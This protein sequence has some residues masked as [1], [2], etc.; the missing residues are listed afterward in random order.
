MQ[1]YLENNEIINK[2]IKDVEDSISRS[3]QSS[4]RLLSEV[5]SSSILSGGLK[6]F[7]LERARANSQPAR[8]GSQEDEYEEEEFEEYYEEDFEALPEGEVADQADEVDAL[9]DLHLQK[10]DPRTAQLLQ[11][12]GQE[13]APYQLP[14]EAPPV[15][16]TQ[17]APTEEEQEL[18]L[19]PDPAD[20]G[21]RSAPILVNSTA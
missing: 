20:Q 10:T 17:P 16:D 7:R 11:T 13:A 1:S 3:L 9:Q 6:G 14:A 2:K 8:L 4:A 19:A 15:A 18:L 5:G 21:L 12:E